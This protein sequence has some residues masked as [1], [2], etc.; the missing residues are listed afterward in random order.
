M[1]QSTQFT[2][3][4]AALAVVVIVVF[5][6]LLV[7]QRDHADEHERFGLSI[8]VEVSGEDQNEVSLTYSR[9]DRADDPSTIKLRRTKGDK[10]CK[11]LPLGALLDP[12][13]I[14]AEVAIVNEARGCE[15][16]QRLTVNNVV[17]SPKF[18]AATKPAI[19]SI[20]C[21]DDKFVFKVVL[22]PG[23]EP[24]VWVS[25]TDP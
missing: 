13:E 12:D 8:C 11:V 7:G 23:Q 16:L 14:L 17:M 3:F 20:A 6:I 24:I 9:S 2:K 22:E 4:E 15:A 21:H 5:L 25:S 19:K 1:S 10:F 18:D